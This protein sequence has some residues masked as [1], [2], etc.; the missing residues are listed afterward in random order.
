MVKLR[1]ANSGR[2]ICVPWSGVFTILIRLDADKLPVYNWDLDQII[3][4]PSGIWGENNCSHLKIEG[5]L[6]QSPRFTLDSNQKWMDPN[7]RLWL[8]PIVCSDSGTTDG[9]WSYSVKGTPNKLFCTVRIKKLDKVSDSRYQYS[10]QIEWHTEFFDSKTG[11]W[12][13]GN[14]G[15]EDRWH[16]TTWPTSAKN[17]FDWEGSGRET[18][19]PKDFIMPP[20]WFMETVD[21]QMSQ[22]NLEFGDL[23]AD[24][25]KS[26]RRLDI[27]MIAYVRDFFHMDQ[28]AHSLVGF[29]GEKTM[30]EGL[31]SI[32]SFFLGNHYGTTLTISDTEKIA[33]AIDA[34]DPW[35]EYQR[36]GAEGQRDIPNIG[37]FTNIRV[38]RR[39]NATI[40]NFDSD[41]LVCAKGVKDAT[42][43]LIN[44]YKRA[45]YELDA[46]PTMDNIWDLIPY[47]FVADWFLPFQKALEQTEVKHYIATYD[48]IKCFMSQSIDCGQ[49]FHTYGPNFEWA[50]R[51]SYH[52]YTRSC[53][54]EIPVPTLRLENPDGNSIHWIEGAAL[55]I[56]MW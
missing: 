17:F 30:K 39:L 33:K 50:G 21:E 53:S 4:T 1:F 41:Q 6:E 18:W 2:Y 37:S 36:L 12:K 27:N 16:T 38:K 51:L 40:R 35:H 44:Q 19:P 34:I 56:Q 24:A 47:S 10:H 3:T 42:H 29:G 20:K 23:A 55:L 7:G 5:T 11:A 54:R 48:V 15:R 28:L 14:A 49:T 13:R 32:S 46:M 25:A 52:W 45:F 9:S 31:K 26:I 22:S 8:R 43:R